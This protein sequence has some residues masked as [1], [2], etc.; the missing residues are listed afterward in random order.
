MCA[1]CGDVIAEA[2]YRPLIGSLTITAPEGYQL[3]PQKG[4][5]LIRIA[6]QQL[7]ASA[8]AQ[9]EQAQKQLTFIK[10]H[11]GE[12]MYDLPCHRGHHTLATAPQ[13]AHALRRAKGNWVSLSELPG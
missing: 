12:V 3:F 6:E 5:I 8:A 9:E 4:A 2:T 1:S 10:R 13:I 11:L 7:A